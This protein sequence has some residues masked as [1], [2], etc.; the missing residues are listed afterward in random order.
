L[1]DKTLSCIPVAQKILNGICT[2]ISA[3]NFNCAC[4][5]SGYMY[6]V[7]LSTITGDFNDN[8]P[9]RGCARFNLSN[10][11][12]WKVNSL[13][14]T[15][16]VLITDTA[17]KALELIC[18]TC[19]TGYNAWNI[20]TPTAGTITYDTGLTGPGC[21]K[22][23]IFDS[24]CVTATIV[25]STNVY[26]CTCAA[27][28]STP[29]KITF[30]TSQSQ[31]ISVGCINSALPFMTGCTNYTYSSPPYTNSV[32]TSCPGTGKTFITAVRDTPAATF[33]Y[34]TTDSNL[35][36]GCSLYVV[37]L[38]GGATEPVAG[39]ALKCS[40]CNSSYDLLPLI[41]VPGTTKVN[42][43]NGITGAC[44]SKGRWIIEPTIC[45]QYDAITS[46]DTFAKCNTCAV[47]CTPVTVGAAC[48]A[49]N[50]KPCY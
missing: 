1:S 20:A 35:I 8:G 26:T 45:A 49:S 36:P 16:T 21:P 38:T 29:N 2:K 47:P 24:T 6:P 50:F 30:V 39:D 23:G 18:K 32:C 14:E 12:T 41:N 9:A 19:T 28:G 4:P 5:T 7:T 34:C 44:V 15:S 13:T 48:T 25:F 37:T 43:T 33:K 40:A 10:C 11:D 3:G 31:N 22:D 27:G 42:G 46:S 17:Y